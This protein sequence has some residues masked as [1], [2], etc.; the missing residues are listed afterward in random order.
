MLNAIPSNLGFSVIV[1][2]NE[3]NSCLDYVDES[4][5]GTSDDSSIY[6]RSRSLIFAIEN[7]TLICS[8]CFLEVAVW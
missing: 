1:R 4:P 8:T 5:L 3:T 6:T 2:T 7:G